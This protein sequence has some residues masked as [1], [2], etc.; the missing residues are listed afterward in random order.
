MP[1]G[2]GEGAAVGCTGRG[3]II[4]LH[5][6][7]DADGLPRQNA[8]HGGAVQRALVEAAVDARLTVSGDSA[9]DFRVVGQQGLVNDGDLYALPRDAARLQGTHAEAGVPARFQQG[10][11]F[12]L[13]PHKDGAVIEGVGVEIEVVV[14]VRL[15]GLLLLKA[16]LRHVGQVVVG[17]RGG[18]RR[19]RGGRGGRGCRSRWG[20]G[21]RNGSFGGG[22]G[23]QGQRQQTGDKAGKT[24]H[25]GTLSL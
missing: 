5:A 17:E 18:L 1:Q 13:G 8:C 7:R 20:C 23:G 21:R 14:F 25:E 22:A 24:F 12:V 10:G 3:H 16:K 4:D 6:R 2:V 15:V 11:G 9:G 19:C